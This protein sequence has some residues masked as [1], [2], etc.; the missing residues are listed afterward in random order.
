MRHCCNGIT[1][2]KRRV[3][4]L[5]PQGFLADRWQA[6]IK[7]NGIPETVT[8]VFRIPFLIDNDSKRVRIL[9]VYA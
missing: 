9:S 2:K 5:Q 6:E 4:A 7:L 8:H 3:N 1:S